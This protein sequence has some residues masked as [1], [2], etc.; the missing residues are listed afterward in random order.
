MPFHPHKKDE[1]DSI[2]PPTKTELDEYRLLTQMIVD[3]VQP[4]KILAL[5]RRAHQQLDLM[6]LPATYVRHP[7]QGGASKFEAGMLA[8][9]SS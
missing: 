6:S 9:F 4:S 8:E 1:M 7:S 5:G 3:L 2:R